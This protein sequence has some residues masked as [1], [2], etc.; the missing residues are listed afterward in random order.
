VVQTGQKPS[1]PVA[2]KPGA[3]PVAQRPGA[4]APAPAARVAL[5]NTGAGSLSEQNGATSVA[6]LGIL[7]G[8]IALSATGLV[9]YRRSR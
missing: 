9:A 4:Y 7:L 6:L 8:A 3:A 5:P 2:Q 1:A